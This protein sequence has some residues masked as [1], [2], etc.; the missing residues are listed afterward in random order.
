[1]PV[2]ELDIV[3]ALVQHNLERIAV[4]N[5]QAVLRD[6]LPRDRQREVGSHAIERMNTSPTTPGLKS[7][8]SGQIMLLGTLVLGMGSFVKVVLLAPPNWMKPLEQTHTDEYAAPRWLKLNGMGMVSP[9]SSQELTVGRR[10]VPGRPPI[11]E[12]IPSPGEME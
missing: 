4:R 6:I 10:A 9:Q 2:P 8:H 5:S 7:S 3:V 11:A 12:K 1:M